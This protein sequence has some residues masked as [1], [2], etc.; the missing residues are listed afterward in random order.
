VA[1]QHS[2]RLELTWT[3]KDKA[4]LS[5]AD[6]KYDYTFVEHT[7][8]RVLE[9][10]V[11]HEVDRFSFPVP[12]NRPPG[13][14]V[15][16]TDNL[17]ITGDAMHALNALRKIPEWAAKYV[18]KVKLVY[19]DPPFNTG[20]TFTDYDD[21]I[22]HSIWL[23]ML[24]DRLKQLKPLLAEDASIWVHLDDVEV[25]RCRAI[26]DEELGIDKFVAT[27]VWEKD[28]GRRNDTDISSAHDYLL[29]YAPLGKKWKDVRNLLPREGQEAR[30]KNPDNDPRG[31]WLQG[32]NG[33][34]KSGKEKNRFPVELP[35]GR[36]VTPGKNYWRFSQE[37]L[38]EARAEGRVWFGKDGDSLPVIKRY[39]SQVQDG[40]VP[41]TWWTADEAGHNQEAKRDHI[42]KMFA[43]HEDGFATPKPERLLQRV[44]QIATSPGDVVLDCFGGSG[45]TAATAHKM[46]RRWVTSELLPETVETFTKQRLLKVLKNEDPRG[47]TTTTV[48]VAAEGVVLPK[49]V[50]P[51]DAQQ[52]QT[53]LGRV[54]DNQLADEDETPATPI[55]IAVDKSLASAVRTARKN[56]NGT[57]TEEEAKT[58]L[59]LLK[60]VG[61][62][63]KL[64]TLDITR[65]VKNDLTKR[66]KTRADTTVNWHGGGGFT[67]L[68]VGPSMYDIDD[69]TGDVYLSEHAVNGI[70]SQS[71]A[72]QLRFTLTPDHPVFCG[73]RGRQRLAVI[74]G[75][76]D[77]VVV[78]TAVEHLADKER[79]VIVAKV[80][81]PEA[82]ALLQELSPGSRLKKAPRDLFPKRTIK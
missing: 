53:M 75:V 14:P 77:E 68:V 27:I 23:T 12:D 25:H 40:L 26:M 28:K 36:V 3:D 7:D 72:A 32:D 2:G 59:S 76:A 44:I 80:V 69:E 48:R 16:T 57:L 52:F 41:R 49:D 70:W 29:V 43:D 82:E 37:S 67:H 54:L 34:A 61:A 66:I 47:I 39:L 20:Q 5:V 33:T 30:Y 74:D 55:T 51:A 4:L 46:G 56:G 38:A 78:R 24:R 60:K 9:V 79:T 73:V 21:N 62:D 19:I 11:L 18:G 50:T 17:L 1:A 63:E 35:S 58:L 81:V 65:Q 22:D 10:R 71:V 13:L 6:G 15:P 42:N 64:S 45:T 31:R 8:P